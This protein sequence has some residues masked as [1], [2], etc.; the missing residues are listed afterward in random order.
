MN[1]YQ[2]NWRRQEALNYLCKAVWRQNTKIEGM[3]YEPQYKRVR[4]RTR[5]AGN[6]FID[7][8]GKD[9][10]SMLLTIIERIQLWQTG[11]AA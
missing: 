7:V 11:G 8:K 10:I 1:D 4:I 3:Y 9:I 5:T 2:E 6:Y